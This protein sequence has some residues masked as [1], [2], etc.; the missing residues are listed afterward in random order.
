MGRQAF[1]RCSDR[2][3]AVLL[4]ATD[5]LGRCCRESQLGSLE[6][7]VNTKTDEQK[8]KSKLMIW[9]IAAAIA[10]LAFYGLDH[11]VMGIQGLP[12]NW[13]MTPAQ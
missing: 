10:L 6:L 2:S 7:V 13:D 5:L 4:V 11:F 1:F 12:L 9:A 8:A 3:T